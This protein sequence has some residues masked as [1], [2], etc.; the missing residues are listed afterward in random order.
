[1]DIPSFHSRKKRVIVLDTETMGL[2]PYDLIVTL[3]G[4][5]REGDELQKQ[6]L[7]F[8]G[9]VP[10]R[11]ASKSVEWIRRNRRENRNGRENSSL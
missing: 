2:L 3:A 4:V 11:T 10:I 6:Y 5:R 1:M 7:I 8:W 9:P